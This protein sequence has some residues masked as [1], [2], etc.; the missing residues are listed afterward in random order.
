MPCERTIEVRQADVLVVLIGGQDILKVRIAALPPNTVHVVASVDTHHVVQI[1]LIDC[2]ILGICQGKLPSHLVGEIQGFF[3]SLHIA[4]SVGSDS[5]YHQ[6]CQN[7]NLLHNQFSYL[8]ELDNLFLVF[9]TMT[10]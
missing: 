2:I 9:T 1:D 3:L 6:H 4:H 5:H 7:H 8:L 10:K